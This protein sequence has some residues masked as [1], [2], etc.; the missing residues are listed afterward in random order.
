MGYVEQLSQ[1]LAPA[2]ETD[3]SRE[4]RRK[5]TPFLGVSLADMH[6]KYCHGQTLSCMAG[7]DA[8]RSVTLRQYV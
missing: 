7:F 6:T 5:V 8:D 3:G 1:R 2:Q 4:L